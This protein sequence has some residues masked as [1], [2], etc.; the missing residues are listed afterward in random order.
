MKNGF[1][2]HPDLVKQPKPVVLNVSVT[3][4]D[5]FEVLLNIALDLYNTLEL[6][7]QPNYDDVSAAQKAKDKA[8]ALFE[9]IIN[10]SEPE[11]ETP[12]QNLTAQPKPSFNQPPTFDDFQ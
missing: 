10:P 3:D 2:S 6:Y 5:A 1:I 7:Q 9:E 4:T 12:A 8:S 11:E